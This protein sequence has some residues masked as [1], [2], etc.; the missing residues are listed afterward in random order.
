[1]KKI[2]F[3]AIG[4][5]VVWVALSILMMW[6]PICRY[7]GESAN[8][9]MND[10]RWI[11]GAKQ[12]YILDTGKTNGPLDAV[13]FEKEYLSGK[14]PV[15]PSGGTYTYG[16]LDQDPV[17]SL[18]TNP[19]PP[20]VKGRQGLFGWYWKVWPSPGPDSHKLPK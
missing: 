19:A 7:D 3:T 12:Q 8:A 4:L 10:L 16:D 17:C 15:C 11:D 2:V 6:P 14:P 13:P 1:M 9:C 18:A 20:A 5:V